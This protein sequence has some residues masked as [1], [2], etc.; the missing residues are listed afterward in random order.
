MHI[1]IVES[2][3]EREGRERE[4]GGREGERGG[5]G[6]EREGEGE[7]ERKNLISHM[8]RKTKWLRG[9]CPVGR[10]V[11]GADSTHWPMGHQ[12]QKTFLVVGVI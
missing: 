5:G 1:Y 8:K 9:P 2:E 12:G 7:R 6:R 3:R 11:G 10:S 4:K